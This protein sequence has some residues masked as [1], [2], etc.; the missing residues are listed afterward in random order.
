MPP[1]LYTKRSRSYDVNTKVEIDPTS[2]ANATVTNDI[3]IISR[4]VESDVTPE[5][6]PLYPS[7]PLIDKSEIMKGV[8]SKLLECFT[9][10]LL[11]NNKGLISNIASKSSII[12]SKSHLEAIV[13]I[14]TQ[15]TSVIAVKSDDDSCCLAKLSPFKRV[16]TIKIMSIDN[17]NSSDFKYSHNEEYRILTDKYHINLNVVVV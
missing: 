16:D 10:I 12:L 2:V 3:K 6:Q 9:E 8:E 15:S 7:V 17:T 1:N 14:I 4:E 5:V 11:S 13:G